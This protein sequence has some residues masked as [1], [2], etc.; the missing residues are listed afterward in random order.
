MNHFKPF[1]LIVL[2]IPFASLAQVDIDVLECSWKVE[3]RASY[4][5]WEQGANG[6]TGYAYKV[7]DGQRI[8]KETL[9]IVMEAGAVVYS[10][11][12]PNQNQGA[13]IPF[14][15]NR[16]EKDLLSFENPQH[17][18]PVKIRYRPE[19][20][21]R[22]FVEVLGADGKGFSFYMDRVSSE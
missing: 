21:D 19:T 6:L 14:T 11:T 18:F 8:I 1:F 16:E 5:V 9:K 4:E 12:V 15:L 22:L 20:A 17:D 3:G 10:A 13:A 7:K 2:F